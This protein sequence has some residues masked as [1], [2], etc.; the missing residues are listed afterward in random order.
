[1]KKIL[2]S[3]IIVLLKKQITQV[4]NPERPIGSF[5]LESGTVIK[6]LDTLE[7]GTRIV[8][9]FCPMTRSAES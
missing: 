6:I 1:L 7:S 5:L 4:F 2:K 3:K 9:S 8:A